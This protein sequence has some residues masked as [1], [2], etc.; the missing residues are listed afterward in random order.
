MWR[1]L[2][3]TVAATITMLPGQ[4]WEVSPLAGYLR[5]SHK[6][7]GSVDS[8][9]PKEDD[10]KLHA[11]QPMI[12]ARLTW[13]TK[14]YYGVEAGYFRSKARIDAQIVPA[15]GTD[16]ITESGRIW[17]NQIS[18]NGICYF[19]PSGE[20][21]RPFVTA[22]GNVHTYSAPPLAD[23][24]LGPAPR[25]IGFNYG[26]GIKLRLFPH[27]QARLDVRDIFTG[28]PYDLSFP[29]TSGSGGRHRQLE[30][31]MGIGLTF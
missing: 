30:A 17:I 31:S 15:G 27:A 24:T 11:F 9:S 20:R 25:A 23:W 13:N 5:L 28:S 21:F 7:I 3:V 14:G 10:T 19:M 1:R 16:P 6:P 26:G 12:G 8:S 2:A 4:T 29:T 22:G 18:V